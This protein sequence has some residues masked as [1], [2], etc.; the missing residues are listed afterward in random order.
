MAKSGF[1][2]LKEVLCSFMLSYVVFMRLKVVLSG[3][4]WFH[5]VNIG[6]MWL[7]VVVCVLKWF[8]VFKS[9]FMWLKVVSCG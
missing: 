5:V 9:G 8:Y 7:K 1:M 6:F 4:E 2:W 3:Y